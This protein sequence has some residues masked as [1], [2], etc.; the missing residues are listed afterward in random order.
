MS[1]A[2]PIEYVCLTGPTACG[3]SA[4]ALELA[5]RLNAEIVALDSMTLYRGMDIGTAKPTAAERARVPH[6]LFDVLDPHEEFSVAEYLAAADRCCRDIVARD[7]VPLFVGGTGL[8][9]RSL[10]R[11]ARKNGDGES[12][13]GALLAGHGRPG[14]LREILARGLGGHVTR[15]LRRFADRRRRPGFA[16]HDALEWVQE[17]IR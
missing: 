1:A 16:K 5:P 9:L 14:V 4:V 15:R 13:G 12:L 11:G 10:L 3:K 17:R 6:H 2:G 7:R 8:Y